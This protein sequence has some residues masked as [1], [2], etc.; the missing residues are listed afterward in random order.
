M[1]EVVQYDD[2]KRKRL[3]IPVDLNTNSR[4]YTKKDTI[5]KIL[6]YPRNEIIEVLKY[7]SE[8]NIEELIEL[9]N[10]IYDDNKFIGFS[11][12]KYG[13]SLRKEK[14]TSL[15]IK[16]KVAKKIISIFQM[17]SNYNLIFSDYHLGNI[18]INE[19]N[20]LKLCDLDCVYISNDEELK[21]K[22]I[23]ESF[24][25]ALGYLYNVDPNYI[26]QVLNSNIDIGQNDLSNLYIKFHHKLD[27]DTAIYLLNSLNLKE[28]PNQRKRIKLIGKE[29]D[30]RVYYDRYF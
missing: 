27:E 13:K 23:L 7:I 28:V 18:L 20:K 5:Y 3:Y 1:L 24:W 30:N 29:L 9:R 22:Q 12:E 4:L 6:Y 8:C 11:F 16:L 19:R 26:K 25:L 14:S 17:L 10:L 15:N 21:N 2:I